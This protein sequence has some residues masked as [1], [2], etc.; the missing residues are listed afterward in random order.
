MTGAR[1]L[2]AE[3]TMGA[4]IVAEKSETKVHCLMNRLSRPPHAKIAG[5]PIGA[6]SNHEDK[7]MKIFNGEIPV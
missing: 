1:G 7:R 2:G 3:R 4:A 5:A 6:L